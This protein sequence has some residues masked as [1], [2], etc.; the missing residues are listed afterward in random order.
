MPDAKKQYVVAP[1]ASF[2]KGERVYSE[3][4]KIDESVFKDP[5]RFNK[6]LKCK[7]PRIIEAPHSDISSK[8]KSQIEDSTDDSEQD[9]TDETEEPIK[10]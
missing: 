7:P 6:F 3:G 9:E 2:L 8:E 1:G 4:D 5:K 10:R